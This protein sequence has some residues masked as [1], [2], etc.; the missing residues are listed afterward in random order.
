[1]KSN[2]DTAYIREQCERRQHHDA[3]IGRTIMNAA[4]GA[5]A[6]LLT[7]AAAPAL[8]VGFEHVTVPD[9]DGAPLEAGIWY[10][11]DAP[12]SP[13]PLGLFAQT[14]AA[15]APVTGRGL[16]LV[17]MSHGTGGTFEGHYDTAL[18]LA[19]AGFVVA[20]VTHAGDNYRDQSAFSRVEN[21]PRHMKALIDY[22]LASWPRHDALDPARIGMFGFSAGGFTALV[23]IGGVPD[24]T[25]VASFCAAHPDDWACNRARE[26]RN[27]PP[28]P[29]AP[30]SA[31]VHDPRIT[32]AI[33]A[34]PAIGYVFTPE[35]LSG[36]KI[37]IQLWRGDRDEILTNPYHA[38]NVHDALPIKPE[39]RV[40]PNAGHFAF[41]APCN[42]A[43]QSIAPDIC[44]DPVGFDRAAFH[45]EFNAAVVAF[46]KAKLPRRL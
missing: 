30:P 46:F 8:A 25:R 3:D 19:E 10:P 14:V 32:A 31:F 6:T 18:A 41:L 1:M 15:G 37:P 33:V 38:Q 16:P 12:A 13:R 4:V 22:M 36:V 17:V 39:Y 2:V 11:S 26:L 42:A 7:L 24:M 21:R 34:A 20:S 28:A 9:P 45:R 23:A 5:L 44:R 29:P 40:V 43:L 27:G 35:G